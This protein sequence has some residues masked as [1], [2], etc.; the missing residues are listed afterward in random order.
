M[1]SFGFGSFPQRYCSRV[2]P[3]PHT[4]TTKAKLCDV[5]L[6]T[7]AARPCGFSC[8]TCTGHSAAASASGL[9][10][11]GR[12]A[13]RN[14]GDVLASLPEERV[15][16]ELQGRLSARLLRFASR[17]STSAAR[18]LDI[19]D[20]LKVMARTER[21]WRARRRKGARASLLAERQN[22]SSCRRMRPIDAQ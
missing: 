22:V 6:P 14:C 1:I 3:F 13:Y 9:A 12:D 11:A 20:V 18:S 7:D 15:P 16:G 10:W 2:A 21:R 4:W 5:R 19:S 17:H 8:V